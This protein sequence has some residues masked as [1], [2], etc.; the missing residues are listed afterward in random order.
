L[1]LK[2]KHLSGRIAHFQSTNDGS[3][4][5]VLIGAGTDPNDTPVISIPTGVKRKDAPIHEPSVCAANL[6]AT[7]DVLGAVKTIHG[8]AIDAIEDFIAKATPNR[9]GVTSPT[10]DKFNRRR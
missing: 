2:C 1:T 4:L 7:L 6:A 3:W 9:S 8:Q 5:P 10:S